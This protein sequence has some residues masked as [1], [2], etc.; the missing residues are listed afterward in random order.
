MVGVLENEGFEVP[1]EMRTREEV[2]GVAVLEKEVL[3]CIA[4]R[5]SARGGCKVGEGESFQRKLEPWVD[6]VQ[7]IDGVVV[8]DVFVVGDGPFL[9]EAGAEGDVEV[10]GGR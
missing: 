1:R 2:E 10:A 7:R 8:R 6:G 3:E 9:A 4:R 5:R